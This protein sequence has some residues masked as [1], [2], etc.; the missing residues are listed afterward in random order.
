MILHFNFF[1]MPNF[2]KTGPAGQGQMTGRG[3]GACTGKSS[4]GFFG[5][6]FGRGCGRGRC[7]GGFFGGFGRGRFF[8][9]GGSTLEEEE[10]FLKNR[11]NAIQ[12]AKKSSTDEK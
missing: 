12:K 3:Q 8:S 7:G 1:T 2:D 6:F 9:Q 10:S 4:S 11:L 5:N